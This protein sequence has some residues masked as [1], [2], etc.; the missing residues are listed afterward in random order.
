MSAAR[1]ALTEEM[2]ATSGWLGQVAA[3]LLIAM[4]ALFILGQAAPDI[5]LTLIAILFLGRS[6]ALRDWRW[7]EEPWV[8]TGLLVW[9]YL[10]LN[11]AYVAGDV[12][13]AI[14]RAAP[15]GRF[16]VFAAALQFWLFVEP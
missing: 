6:I 15:F 9:I 13:A 3:L 16:I 10:M 1:A 12:E 4:P 5:A 2:G 14:S 8:L 7:L 11:A